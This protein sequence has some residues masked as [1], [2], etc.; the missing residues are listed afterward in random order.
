MHSRLRGNDAVGETIEVRPV[1]PAD[2]AELADLLNAIIARGGTTA[3]EE[4]Y[5]PEKLADAYLTG[6]DVLCCFVA[7]DPRTGRIEGFQTL[8]R[9]ATLP[10]DIG[11]IGTFAR[12]GGTQ[13]GVGS[14]L[15]AATRTRAHRLGL[16][17]INATIRADNEGGLAFYARQGF[18]DHD[19]I[20]AVPLKDGTPV[21]RIMKRYALGVGA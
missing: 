15:F 3:L 12:V 16:T 9:Y 2:A 14:A 20:R 13:R 4:P 17:A 11:D 7:V 19:V 8:G 21:D 10:A 5:T 18:V 1:A 6:P